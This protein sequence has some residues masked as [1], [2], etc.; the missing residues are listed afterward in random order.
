MAA[1]A[2]LKS[3]LRFGVFELDATTGELRKNGVRLKL[4]PQ[5]VKVLILLASRAG[6]LITRDDLK[7][8]LWDEDTFVDFEQ[9]LNSCIRQIR[10]ALTDD[11]DTPR[12]I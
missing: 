2:S 12:Y 9:G 6:D 11:P 5:P 4:Q 10:N 3:G 8:T 7:K 1:R